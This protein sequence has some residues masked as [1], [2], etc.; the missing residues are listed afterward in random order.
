MY[1]H[2]NISKYL[3]TTYL[4]SASD[5]CD[6]FVWRWR[7]VQD[8]FAFFDFSFF[9]LWSYLPAVVINV[10]MFMFM[11]NLLFIIKNILIFWA[12][13]LYRTNNHRWQSGTIII[14]SF[15]NLLVTSQNMTRIVVWLRLRQWGGMYE[16]PR[17][18]MYVFLLIK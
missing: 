7:T 6:C 11:K 18:S 15:P 12:F 2:L 9:K 3:H 13:H 16:V 5:Y 14:P 4:T 8:N 10:I 1:I 17:G